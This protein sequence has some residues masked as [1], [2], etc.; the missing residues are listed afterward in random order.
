MVDQSVD[1]GAGQSRAPCSAGGSPRAH[2]G[3]E[4]VPDDAEAHDPRDGA[5]S[6]SSVASE[7]QAAEQLRDVVRRRTGAEVVAYDQLAVGAETADEL[8][9]LQGEQAAVG[10]ELDDVAGDLLG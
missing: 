4:R 5:R 3:V 7:R 10:A 6:S 1:D 2:G 8:V 9:E